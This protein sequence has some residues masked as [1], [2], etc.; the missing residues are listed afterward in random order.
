[1]ITGMST[2]A[3]L[4]RDIKKTV[5]RLPADRLASLADFAAFLDRPALGQR[6]TAAEQAFKSGKG[7]NWRKVRRRDV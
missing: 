6:L 2:T 3:A 1:M 4:R 7:I 5:D